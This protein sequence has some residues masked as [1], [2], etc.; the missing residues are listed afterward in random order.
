MDLELEEIWGFLCMSKVS[1]GGFSLG[2][3]FPVLGE[4][5]GPSDSS[6]MG[7]QEGALL[8]SVTQLLSS[9]HS[10]L[11]SPQRG[12][13]LPCSI[14]ALCSPFPAGRA[15]EFPEADEDPAEEAEPAGAGEGSPAERAQQG[16]P[17]PEQAGEPVPGAAEAQPHPQ[18]EFLQPLLLP[19][20][21]DPSPWALHEPFWQIHLPQCL[22]PLC[23]QGSA[24]DFGVEPALPTASK[25]LFQGLSTEKRKGGRLR[26]LS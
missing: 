1:L 5:A 7:I 2:S 26:V 10:E 18:G 9:G 16:H 21:L 8:R 12:P 25:S 13:A 22:P 6:R 23:H 15:P 20:L 14:P 4:P 11:V 24:F 19:E 3:P 17:G